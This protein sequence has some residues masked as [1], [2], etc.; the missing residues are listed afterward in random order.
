M[1]PI[2]PGDL[3]RR[4]QNGLDQVRGRGLA[5]GAGDAGELHALI[6]VPVE[7]ARSRG[8]RVA[9][10]LDLDPWRPGNS[11]GRGDSLAIASAPCASASCANWRPSTRDPANAKNTKPFPTRR[12]SYSRPATSRSASA[13]VS[14]SRSVTPASSSLSFIARTEPEPVRE[15]AEEFRVAGPGCAPARSRALPRE[16]GRGRFLQHGPQRLPRNR[17]HAARQTSPHS[18]S[19][20][21]AGPGKM[22]RPKPKHPLE[23]AAE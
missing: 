6:G 13:G 2:S 4:P 22:S 23:P 1:V 21:A 3:A 8:Q 20:K 17:A 14:A 5:V 7:I 16:T 19:K 12:E 11:A 15:D 18:R 9:A 10:V